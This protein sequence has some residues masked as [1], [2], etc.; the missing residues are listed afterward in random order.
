MIISM[1]RSLL[2]LV[3][4]VSC[5]SCRRGTFDSPK[6]AIEGL[7]E[8]KKMCVQLDMRMWHFV[9][10]AQ[11]ADTALVPLTERA[12]GVP[13]SSSWRVSFAIDA[14]GLTSGVI[15]RKYADNEPQYPEGSLGLVGMSTDDPV[16][17][18]VLSRGDVQWFDA[19]GNELANGW[20]GD[21]ETAWWQMFIDQLHPRTYVSDT[22]F[23]ALLTS[24]ESLGL[25][26]TH[27]N[28]RIAVI[29]QVNNQ[30]YVNWVVDKQLQVVCGMDAYDADGILNHSQR[31]IF[32]S[33]G[34]PYLYWFRTFYDSPLTGKRM[35]F[36][37]VAEISNLF[38]E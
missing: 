9:G 33:S 7:C 38:I 15:E 12:M 29:K 14:N 4:F 32:N 30:G 16:H 20:Q 17:R 19:Q 3:V 37:R 2:L 8:G 11:A 35:I 23:Q 1:W 31:L 22:L 24:M 27:V 5:L 34:T 26:L 18:I 36:H 6:W 21:E 28:N 25:S 13:I 10:P